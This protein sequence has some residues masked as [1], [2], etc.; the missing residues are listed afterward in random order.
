MN[1][2]SSRAANASVCVAKHDP[3]HF[4]EFTS[5]LFSRQPPEGTA[6]PTN[7]ELLATAA[8]SGVV[9][10]TSLSSCV[11]KGSYKNWVSE[12]T[13]KT[14]GAKVPGTTHSLAGVPVISIGSKVYPG[15]LNDAQA[16]TSWANSVL[17]AG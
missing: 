3:D 13:A 6:G 10:S 11:E 4:F 12:T 1:S 2:Y 7:T 9:G 17:A 8:T 14:L 16:F 5:E 15:A